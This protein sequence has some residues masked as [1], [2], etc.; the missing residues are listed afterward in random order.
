MRFERLYSMYAPQEAYHHFEALGPSV[1]F[2]L[3]CSDSPESCYD[4]VKNGLW[5]LFFKL[6]KRKIIG[7][8][9]SGTL[10]NDY[11]VVITFYITYFRHGEMQYLITDAKRDCFG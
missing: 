4:N 6:G 10:M 5:K 1:R 2:P 3:L 11:V 7:V 9:V 8:A